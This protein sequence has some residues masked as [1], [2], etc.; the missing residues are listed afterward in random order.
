[1]SGM[2]SDFQVLVKC[3]LGDGQP[4]NMDARE[5]EGP[6]ITRENG[7]EVVEYKFAGKVVHRSEAQI[8]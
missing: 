2:I 4:R 6:F 3:D 8:A 1:M 5:L 7:K